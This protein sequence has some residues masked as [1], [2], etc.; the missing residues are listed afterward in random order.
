MRTAIP[1]LFA[2]SLSCASDKGIAIH[3]SAPEVTIYNPDDGSEHWLGD[4]IDFT[5]QIGDDRDDATR[6]IRVWQSDLQGSFEDTSTVGADGSVTWST[7]QLESG[8]H[9]ISLQVIDSEGLTNSASVRITV[10]DPD[11]RPRITMIH[12]TGTES[13][14]AGVLFEFVAEVHDGQDEPGE[15]DIVFESSEDGVFCNPTADNDGIALCEASLTEGTHYLEYTVTDTEG[16]SNKDPEVWPFTVEAFA[17]TDDDGDG[18][19]EN[20]GDCDDTDYYVNPGATETPYDGIDQDCDGSDLTDVDGDGHDAEVV[21]GDDCNDNA[22]SAHPGADEVCDDVDNNCNGVVDEEDA[23]GCTAWYKDEDDDGHGVFED[24]GCFCGASGD[25]T[26]DGTEGWDCE[27]DASEVNPSYEG[28]ATFETPGG[29]WDWNCDGADER[30][31]EGYGSCSGDFFGCSLDSVGWGGA[32]PACG[33][34]G[35]WVDDCV[36]AT[37]E[38]SGTMKTQRCR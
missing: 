2:L 23:T 5:A 14:E 37:C 27:D 24:S 33:D 11:F 29:N 12:P 6:L 7:S 35:V 34:D 20:T 31:L 22:E 36:G 32:T 3:N 25:Y 30:E 1:V 4:T 13:G 26:A 18:F 38:A 9:T 21:G 8:N 28:W 16:N 17:H 10:E 15:L 19:D